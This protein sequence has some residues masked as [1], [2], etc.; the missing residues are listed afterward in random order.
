MQTSH[1][2]ARLLG[3]PLVVI[4][5]GMLLHAPVLL[6]AAAQSLNSPAL[7]YFAA[8]AGLIGG[9]AIVLAHNVWTADWRVLITLLGWIGIADSALWLLLADAYVSFW[10]GILTSSAVAHAGGAV[11]LLLGAILCYF[12]YAAARRTPD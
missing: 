9:V 5:A 4:G 8:A 7:L 11:T 6:A 2:L 12:G 10:A 1:Y 3:P